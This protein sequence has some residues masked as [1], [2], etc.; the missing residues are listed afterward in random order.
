MI[1][2]YPVIT[3]NDEFTHKGSKR[4]LLGEN[5][6]PQLV[7][8]MSNEKQIG[9]ETPPT[10]LVLSNSDIVV[11][12]ENSVLFYLGLRKAGVPAEMHI[13]ENG[14]HGFG[15]APGDPFLSEWPTLCINWFKMRCLLKNEQG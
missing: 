6:N 7:T 5:P 8:L 1:L 9:S 2:N 10:F 11:P 14:K 12:A 4:N 15:L 3:M 13:F